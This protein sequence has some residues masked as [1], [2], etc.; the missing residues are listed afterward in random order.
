MRLKI[1]NTNRKRKVQFDKDVVINF[2]QND[3]PRKINTDKNNFGAGKKQNQRE[4]NNI[5]GIL[6]KNNKG[7][8]INEKKKRLFILKLKIFFQKKDSNMK[9]FPKINIISNNESKKMIIKGK[10]INIIKPLKDF[11]QNEKLKIENNNLIEHTYNKR[12]A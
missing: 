3:E 11:N 9:K 8:I 6:S 4:K 1:N 5:K 10:K 12:I 7:K 2:D